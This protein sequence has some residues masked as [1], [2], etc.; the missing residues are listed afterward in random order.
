MEKKANPVRDKINQIK[1]T[2]RDFRGDV[3]AGSFNG[4]IFGLIYSFYFLPIDRR[5]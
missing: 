1:Y 3:I 5:D 2:A 4:A